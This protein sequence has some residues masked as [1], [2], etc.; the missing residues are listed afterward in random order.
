MTHRKLTL[1]RESLTELSVEDLNAVVGAEA[2]DLPDVP[3]LR[4]GINDIGRCLTVRC[5]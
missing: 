3:T 5:I 4:Y 1:N 2:P